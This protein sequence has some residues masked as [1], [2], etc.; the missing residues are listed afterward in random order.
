MKWIVRIIG[1]LV[2]I[3]VLVV[4]GL[5]MLP[6]DRIAGIAADQLRKV[7]GRDVTISG[8]V[9]MTFWPVLGVRPANL[10]SAMPTGPRKV[11]C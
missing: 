5:L 1:A 9:S 7:T 10:R 8:G 6:A 4:V 11:R 2:L 3:L